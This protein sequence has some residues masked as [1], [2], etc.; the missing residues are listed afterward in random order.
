MRTKE[1]PH[2]FG[3]SVNI[4]QRPRA[5][6]GPAPPILAT[7]LPLVLSEP[8]RQRLV[9]ELHLANLH[10]RELA[11][12]ARSVKPPRAELERAI[13]AAWTNLA[14]VERAA[15]L[16]A[17]VNKASTA[18]RILVVDDSADMRFLVAR[19]LKTVA[20]EAIIETAGD[21]S[22]ALALLGDVGPG[23]GITII[24]DLD[25]GPGPTGVDLLAVIASRHPRSHRV[26]FTG[27]PPERFE[28]VTVEAH[29]LL[30]KDAPDALRRYFGAP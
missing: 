3:E 23:D 17:T 21:A 30:S 1:K 4:A 12:T 27:H 29:A 15:G 2:M 28:R 10:L 20:P 16:G 26:L 19:T 13:T 11:R 22:Q 8:L 24:S 18:R 25:M 6:M 9:D 7:S 5:R 14:T